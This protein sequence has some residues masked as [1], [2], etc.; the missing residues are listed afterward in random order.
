[1][2]RAFGPNQP[3]CPTFIIP[4]DEYGSYHNLAKCE[5]G[6]AHEIAQLVM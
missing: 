3:R 5:S 2:P 6:A 1:M 4:P